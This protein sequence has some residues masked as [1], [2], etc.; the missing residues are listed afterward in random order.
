MSYLGCHMYNEVDEEI[1]KPAK[2]VFEI[3]DF[4]AATEW[5]NFI[6]DIENVFRK[7]KICQTQS[8]IKELSRN[9]FLNFKWKCR[10][11]KLEFYYFP[12]VLFHYKLDDAAGSEEVI[13]SDS[14]HNGKDIMDIDIS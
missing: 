2:D 3:N 9:D 14:E 6:D 5:E 11:E 12:F 8:D 13:D 1:I 4:T 7:W 10:K